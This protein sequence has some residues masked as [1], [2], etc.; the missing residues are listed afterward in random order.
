MSD[1][2]DLEQSSRKW[3]KQ[4]REAR[5]KKQPAKALLYSKQALEDALLYFYQSQPSREEE[6][7]ACWYRLTEKSPEELEE[8]FKL[9]SAYGFNC[10]CPETIY[11]GYAIYPD[12]H[13]QL[14][15][16]PAFQGWDP[17]ET[18]CRLGKEYNIKVIPWVEVYFVGFED[19]P[20]IKQFGHWLAMS[21]TGG[22]ASELE[23]GYYYFCPS[24]KEIRTFWLEVYKHL[25]ETYDI[26]GLQLDYIRYPRS[27]PWEKGYCYCSHCREQ[28][29][30][31]YEIDPASLDPDKDKE[32]WL[33]WNKF[34]K[35]QV[36][37]FVK[38]VRDL[39]AGVRPDVRLSADVF[40]DSEAAEESK[41][42]DWPLW[43][44]KRYLDE[45]FIMSYTT[46]QDQVRRDTEGMVNLLPEG[47]EGY[48]GLGPYL[49]FGSR[50]LLQEITTA[51]EA[52]AHG[53]CLFSLEH[54]NDQHLDALKLGPFREKATGPK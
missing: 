24:R 47:I 17:L 50:V 49:G 33:N 20:L 54:L 51:G 34:R 39:V 18:L 3:A 36:N 40:P 29:F 52:G 37:T 27:D 11:W 26:D 43:L 46:D 44:E 6:L 22:H 7:R 30:N 14:E 45:I 35:E 31:K 25:L 19:S 53:V 15:Q 12:A 38:Q 10:I 5:E 41:L 21:H 8:T 4:A 23:K 28:F 32:M 9:L 16:N 13:A 48:T 1:L 2:R 42:Q